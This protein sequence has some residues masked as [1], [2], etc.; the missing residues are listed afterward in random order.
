MNRYD[1]GLWDVGKRQLYVEKRKASKLPLFAVTH[2]TVLTDSTST[3][4]E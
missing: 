4:T 3:K 2:E 1:L